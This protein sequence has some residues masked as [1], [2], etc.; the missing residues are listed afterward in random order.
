MKKLMY[1][2]KQFQSEKNNIFKITPVV[3]KTKDFQIKTLTP[4]QVQ[5]KVNST[6]TDH[7]NIKK[8]LKMI[9]L[10]K[11]EKL[12]RDLESKNF[13]TKL[14]A[15]AKE[16]QGRDQVIETVETLGSNPEEEEKKRKKEIFGQTPQQTEE[17]EQVELT[18]QEKMNEKQTSSQ[19]KESFSKLLRPQKEK[20]KK[21]LKRQVT[22][23]PIMEPSKSFK[24]IEEAIKAA[25]EEMVVKKSQTKES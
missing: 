22:F 8:K 24:N 13:V 25:K 15:H 10:K 14:K 5:G 3:S 23:K 2:T 16:E 20:K 11:M 4:S 12:Q 7:T 18:F 21:E 1:K 19:N 17:S 6:S 9:K